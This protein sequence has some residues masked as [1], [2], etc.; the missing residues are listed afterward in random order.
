MQNGQL[1]NLQTTLADI[2]HSWKAIYP[3]EN[4]K[5]NFFEDSI[6][7]F[8]AKEIQAAQ[9]VNAVT[10]LAIF[11]SCM[12]LLGLATHTTSQ[13]RKEVSIRKVLGA[14]ATNIVGLLSAGILQPVAIAVLTACPLAWLAMHA[15]LQNFAYRVNIS[16]WVFAAA[17]IAGLLAALLT[18]GYHTVKAAIANPADSLREG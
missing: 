3:Q 12:G 14:S 13:R 4:F 9:L 18:I 5:W 11:I 17:G 6:N 10:V 8:Y 16:W 7:N 1:P 2:E 15:W